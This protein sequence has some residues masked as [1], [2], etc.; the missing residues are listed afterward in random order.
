M[1]PCWLS[2]HRLVAFLLVTPACADDDGDDPSGEQESEGM[3]EGQPA[4]TCIEGCNPL[5]QD[6][7]PGRAC[8]PD[9]L[10]FGCATVQGTIDGIRR[11][12]HDAC[13]V[14]SQTCDAGLVCLQVAVPGCVGGS[15]CCVAICDMTDPECTD[16][17]MC[18]PFFEASAMCF[19]N[20]GACVL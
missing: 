13:E 15:G 11:G 17:T 12:L 9:Q 8:L 2:T 20:V 4:E 19:E 3:D 6:C 18:Y 14:G 5:E 1:A 16:G 10:G 7:G